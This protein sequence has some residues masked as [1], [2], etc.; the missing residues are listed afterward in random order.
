M[1]LSVVIVNY[2][3]KYFLEQALHSVMRA[4]QHLEVGTG[5]SWEVWVVDNNSVDGSMEMVRE[6]F[7][8]VKCIENKENLGFSKAN[9]QAMRQ[10][11]GEYVLLLNPD[12]V[13]EEDTFLKSVNFMD[14]HPDAGGLG[15]KMLDGKGNFLPESKRG[16]PTPR[17]A[18]YK[19]SGLSGLF[20]KSRMFG[21]Y[22]LGYLDED[23]VNRV[24]VLAGAFMLMR[25]KTL[26]EVGLLDEDYFMYGEDIDLSYRII[27]GGYN[28]Y[29][30]PHTRI[31]HY[32]GESTKKGSLNYVFIF[33]RAMII[34]A[35]KHFSASNARTFALLI[36]FAIYLRAGASL[37][38]RFLK[39]VTLPAADAVALYG[40]MYA[41]KNYWEAT[42][43][44]IDGG[45]YPLEFMLFAV[46]GYVLFWL[47]GVALTGGYHRPY[48]FSKIIKGVAL[49]TVFIAVIYAF[50]PESLRFSRALIVMGA[51]MAAAVMLLTRLATHFLREKNLDYTAS[52]SKR[53]AIVGSQKEAERVVSLLE[54]SRINFTL[55]GY[56]DPAE[57]NGR[58]EHYI[59]NL[60][61]LQEVVAIYQVNELIF[62][63][64]DVKAREI[65]NW[66]G[67]LESREVQFKIVPQD[68]LFIIGS[69]S[70]NQQGDLYTVQLQLNLA[71]P[72]KRFNKRLLDVG[73][74]LLFVLI[75]PYLL[76]RVKD[77]SGF[78]SNCWQ[79]FTGKKTWVGYLPLKQV[80]LLPKLK[81]GVLT[82]QDKTGYRQLSLPMLERL[83]F[84]YARDYN[85]DQD[86]DIIFSSLRHL[87]RQQLIAMNEKHHQHQRGSASNRAVQP[88]N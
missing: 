53:I 17:V 12:T 58:H 3:V 51:I 84:L 1:K 24:E 28:N 65:I 72:Q 35:R 5:E 32:K 79:V 31:I 48:Y 57:E 70:K 11:Q 41:L 47:I 25:K 64:R 42:V 46:P 27:K 21:R 14:A 36:N 16:L 71:H 80:A 86:I 83:N 60:R 2:N 10:A 85:V 9:N 37:L 49:G 78:F 45:E 52:R 40:G 33:Y 26:D 55:I 22:H 39:K 82:P 69:N 67:R 50:L 29:Y 66:M 6:K 77:R 4:G 38:S 44:Y 43:K 61:Q 23:E 74:S 88:G 87:G 34:F 56:I 18:F 81:P 54:R 76:F 73:L 59:G 75:S 30:F 7:P 19:V 20:P 63:S 8:Q 68:S 15:V 13:V 62:C